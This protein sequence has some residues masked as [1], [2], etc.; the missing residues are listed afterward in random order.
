MRLTCNVPLSDSNASQTSTCMHVNVL[1][2]ACSMCQGCADHMLEVPDEYAVP[3]C[4]RLAAPVAVA[5]QRMQRDAR[6]CCQPEDCCGTAGTPHQP[7]GHV[8]CA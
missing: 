7:C 5:V 1:W 4:R 6:L 2:I 8:Q 3:L